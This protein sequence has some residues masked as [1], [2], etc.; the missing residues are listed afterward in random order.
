M[1]L[2]QA[3][4]ELALA[5]GAWGEAVRA[6]TDVIDRAGHGIGPKYEAL[7]L[8]SESPAAHRLGAKSAVK[9]RG[10]R[11]MVARR[12]ADPAVLLESLIVLLEIE[13]SDALLEEARQTAQRIL[14]AVSDASLA[15]GLRHVGGRQG[16]P[17]P[18]NLIA[19][20]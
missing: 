4:A 19:C 11:W 10:P 12:L 5:R 7:G 1:R 16:S 13:G 17:G 3:R 2:S 8:V 9:E 18:C 15:V 20:R 14:R 6:A